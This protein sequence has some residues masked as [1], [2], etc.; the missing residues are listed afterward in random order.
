MSGFTVSQ[1]IED[2]SN[3]V[4]PNVNGNIGELNCSS[5]NSLPYAV[6]IDKEFNNSNINNIST[7]T[8]SNLQDVET[9]GNRQRSSQAETIE[10]RKIRCVLTARLFSLLAF[11]FFVFMFFFSGVCIFIR[12]TIARWI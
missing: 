6:D 12:G 4:G 7:L 5:C 10:V 9:T 8:N 1:K 2:Q 3:D 11:Y